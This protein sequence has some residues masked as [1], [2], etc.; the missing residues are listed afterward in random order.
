[1]S[2]QFRTVFFVVAK[3]GVY[4]SPELGTFLVAQKSGV[5]GQGDLFLEALAFFQNWLFFFFQNWGS[6]DSLLYCVVIKWK[7]S[8]KDSLLLPSLI[9]AVARAIYRSHQLD[10][11]HLNPNINDWDHLVGQLTIRT[12]ITWS[13]NGRNE[14]I[15]WAWEP[16]SSNRSW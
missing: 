14:A 4:M 6:T 5:R 12:P 11:H 10:D 7:F 1:M 2:G 15:P 9:S 13:T 8:I 3:T 16:Y